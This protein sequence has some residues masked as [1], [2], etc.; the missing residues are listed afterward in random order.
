[1][2]PDRE[3]NSQ[4]TNRNS[5][6]YENHDSKPQ[7]VTLNRRK[8]K[9]NVQRTVQMYAQPKQNANHSK[10]NEKYNEISSKK[11]GIL[12]T[13]CRYAANEMHYH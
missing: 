10:M 8:K 3:A 12:S 6:E 11:R 13:T 5:Q 2:C 9:K 7:L 4:F 1:M